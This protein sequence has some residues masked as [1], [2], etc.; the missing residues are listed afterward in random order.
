MQQS[1]PGDVSGAAAA[2]CDWFA[3]SFDAVPPL[4]AV[5]CCACL[6]TMLF[7]RG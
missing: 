5:L 6:P 2:R 1:G 7:R 3:D 4:I